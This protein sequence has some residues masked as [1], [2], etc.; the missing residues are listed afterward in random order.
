MDDLFEGEMNDR[1]EIKRLS[2]VIE[3][4]RRAGIKLRNELSDFVD[5]AK[6]DNESNTVFPK[7]Q[8][9]INEWNQLIKQSDLA[10]KEDILTA[11]CEATLKFLD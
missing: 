7:A 9:A 4:M 1:E 3:D 6:F 11:P 2:G 8:E 5:T 10:W